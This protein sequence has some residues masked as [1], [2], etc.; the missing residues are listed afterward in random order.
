MTH[1]TWPEHWTSEQ[2]RTQYYSLRM[3]IIGQSIRLELL[4]LENPARA[5]SKRQTLATKLAIA[6]RA[7]NQIFRKYARAK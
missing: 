2:A 7:S 6:T 3:M 5:K 4:L 1:F